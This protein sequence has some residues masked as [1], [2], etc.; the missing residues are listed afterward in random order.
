L[1]QDIKDLDRQ[2]R[3]QAEELAAFR[4]TLRSDIGALQEDIT[5]IRTTIQSAPKDPGSL[6]FAPVPPPSRYSAPPPSGPSTSRRQTTPF[7]Y[8]LPEHKG[9]RKTPKRE[10]SFGLEDKDEED[11]GMGIRLKM[12]E[13]FDGKTRGKAVKQWGV[14]MALYLAQPKWSMAS[15]EERIVCILQTSA[16]TGYLISARSLSQISER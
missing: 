16:K 3:A 12:P 6:T 2:N 9:K 4:S 8:R 14:Q 7:E 13:A 11:P 1:I 5:S 10:T 15:E